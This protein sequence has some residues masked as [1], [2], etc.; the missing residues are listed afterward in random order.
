MYIRLKELRE[1][2]GLTQAEFGESIGVAKSTYNNYEI[3]V[4][5]PKSDFWIAVAKK[6]GVTID[7]LM[8]FSDTPYP[9]ILNKKSPSTT[10]VAP[11]DRYISIEESNRLLVALGLVKEGQQLSDDDLAFLTHVIGLLEAWFSKGQ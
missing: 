6:Y 1:S 7:Y 10:E 8:G 3:G 11:G 4:R 9:E 5:D 2:L